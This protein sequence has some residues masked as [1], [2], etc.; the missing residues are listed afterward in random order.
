MPSAT[1][2]PERRSEHTIYDLPIEAFLGNDSGVLIESSIQTLKHREDGGTSTE[3]EGHLYTWQLFAA[4][5]GALLYI[6]KMLVQLLVL[7]LILREAANF[8]CLEIQS[9][10]VPTSLPPRLCQPIFSMYTS[11][12]SD[13]PT[14]KTR[15][16]GIS[17]RASILTAKWV[18]TMEDLLEALFNKGEN[19]GFHEVEIRIVLGLTTP[20]PPPSWWSIQGPLNPDSPVEFDQRSAFDMLADPPVFGQ[21]WKFPGHS[22]H[23]GIQLRKPASIASILLA[24]PRPEQLS[25]S[26]LQHLP[27]RFQ[28]WGHPAKATSRV[29]DCQKDSDKTKR[30][31]EFIT[32][33]ELPPSILRDDVVCLLLEGQLST[34]RL[35]A[36]H[37]FPVR[38]PGRVRQAYD[39]VVFE[40][41]SNWGAASTWV[42]HLAIHTEVQ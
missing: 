24:Y 22:A 41:L 7:A 29:A 26:T 16:L 34:E 5:L 32:S 11:T 28:V 39:V 23:V 12:T 40:V 19:A 25:R 13:W 36:R 31:S 1:P 14:M 6:S 20:S 9:R 17:H 21:C 27:K 3:H 38:S 8:G 15:A 2:S 35:D 33:E 30:L 10:W 18:S 4:L 37:I 42:Y